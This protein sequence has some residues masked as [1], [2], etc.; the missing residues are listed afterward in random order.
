MHVDIFTLCD[1]ATADGGK[2]NILG[3]FDTI[4]VEKF[5][6]IHPQC[7]VALRVRFRPSER[8]D[9][10]VSMELV[11]EDGRPVIPALQL[12]LTVDIAPPER[13]TTI[14]VAFNMQRLVFPNEGEYAVNLVID[15]E[16][17]ASFQLMLRKAQRS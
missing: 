3:A 17:K 6:A 8:G 16:E 5:P 4:F 1:A 10:Q 14:A 15:R 2:L 11:D 13:F 9:H 12:T 7:A